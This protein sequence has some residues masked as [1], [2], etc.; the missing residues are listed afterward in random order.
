MTKNPNWI[1]F[2]D[3]IW[4]EAVG[5]TDHNDFLRSLD[6]PELP[7]S[8]LD[9]LPDHN[10]PLVL[11]WLQEHLLELVEAERMR[12]VGPHGITFARH[13]DMLAEVAHLDAGG[14]AATGDLRDQI[15]RQHWEAKQE[16]ADFEHSPR[17]QAALTHYLDAAGPAFERIAAATPENQAAVV[18]QQQAVER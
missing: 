11:T 14:R 18:Y 6:A 15:T 3:D 16:L 8:A 12:V 9:P 10:A 5:D 17:F 4:G 2:T 7:P 13:A 1:Q